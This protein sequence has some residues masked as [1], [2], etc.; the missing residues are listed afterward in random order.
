MNDMDGVSN[1]TDDLTGVTVSPIDGTDYVQ[2]FGAVGMDIL[3]TLLS[4]S[5]DQFQKWLLAIENKDHNGNPLSDLA[6]Q[7]SMPI[8]V[9]A[10]LA[11]AKTQT[12]T[13]ETFLNSIQQQQKEQ[14]KNIKESIV[15]SQAKMEKLMEVISGKD[16]NWAAKAGISPSGL[17]TIDNGGSSNNSCA[18]VIVGFVCIAVMSI[19]TVLSCG[20][21]LLILALAMILTSIVTSLVKPFLSDK[22]KQ[23]MDNV[24]SW[25]P[26]STDFW[27]EFTIDLYCKISGE[28]INS[29]NVQKA[30]MWLKVAAAILMALA[31]VIAAVAI[32]IVSAGSATAAAIQ[33]IVGAVFGVIDAVEQIMVGI[34]DLKRAEKMVNLA[35]KKFDLSILTAQLEKL[36]A[37]LNQISVEINM[38]T[39]MFGQAASEVAKEY[40]VASDTLKEYNDTM[41]NIARNIQA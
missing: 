24:L 17:Q 5:D 18:R 9:A 25:C 40:T 34:Q 36:K 10:L 30:R 13:M 22:Q 11:V 16:N 32:S 23:K 39:D 21:A 41:A 26:I 3:P 4:S 35:H 8:F 29:K 15:T 37:A 12:M 31:T 20:A 28:D 1:Y 19:L 14:D 2:A 38:L 6:A 7:G 27:V 33:A